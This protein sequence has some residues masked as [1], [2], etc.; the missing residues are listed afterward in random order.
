MDEET[1]QIQVDVEKCIG[2][3]ICTLACAQGSLKLYRHER[4]RSFDTSQELLE[5]VARE[6]REG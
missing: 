5:T 2:C 6:N 4:S 3:G 1:D